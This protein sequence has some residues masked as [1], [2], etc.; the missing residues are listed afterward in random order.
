MFHVKHLRSVEAAAGT[1]RVEPRRNHRPSAPALPPEPVGA[2]LLSPAAMRRWQSLCRTILSFDDWRRMFHVKHLRSIET[3]AVTTRVQPLR[4]HR[5]SAPALPPEPIGAF[6]PS[7]ATMQSWQTLCRAIHG[8][9]DWRR[10]FHVKLSGPSK[11]LRERPAWSLAGTIA[12]AR[13][14][15]RQNRS[16]LSSCH[17]RPCGDGNHSPRQFAVL[18]TG[19]E[20]FVPIR[21]MQTP[22]TCRMLPLTG[23]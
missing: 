22:T 2:F 21:L 10:M 11:R 1:T 16:V 3:T 7:P 15:C 12:Q 6:P 20:C 8:F 9:D 14:R 5:P 13:W 18:T 23:I 17:L 19:A 4:N